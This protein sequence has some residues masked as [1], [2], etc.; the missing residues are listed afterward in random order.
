M[1]T[2]PATKSTAAYFAQSG[3][4]FATALGSLI[5]GVAVLPVDGWI[6]AFLAVS[7]LFLVTSTFTLAKC[8]RDAQENA[9]LSSR[10]DQ[11][12]VDRILAE[13]DPFKDLNNV[14]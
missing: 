13:H 7:G 3:I 6:R 8:V 5:I 12:R 9:G 14:A 10:L 11:A 1:S 4:A 2:V